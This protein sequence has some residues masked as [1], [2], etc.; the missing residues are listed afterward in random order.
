MDD[1]YGTCT[2]YCDAVG[3][4]CVGAWEESGDTCSV[5]ST[6]DCSHN[7]GGYTSDA[8]CECGDQ[9]ASWFLV[10][11]D[12]CWHGGCGKGGLCENIC[13]TNGYCCRSGFNDCPSDAQQV[14]ISSHHICVKTKGGSISSNCD[15][16]TWPDKDHGLVCGE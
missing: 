3:R 14:A 10:S 15:E 9:I 6:K 4:T 1:K 2:A 11:S 5:K 7:F 16:S 12:D 8:I 13:G